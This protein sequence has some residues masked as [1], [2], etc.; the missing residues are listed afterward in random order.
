MRKVH[1]F[2]S[3][4]SLSACLMATPALA[5]PDGYYNTIFGVCLPNG[6]TVVEGAARPLTEAGAV[7]A[8]IVLEQWIVNSRNS[9][10]GSSS[11]IPPHIRYQ[12][13]P[14]FDPGVLSIARYKTGDSGFF[15]AGRNILFNGS[16][17]AVTLKDL[18]V[19][20]NF[21][22]SQSNV[23]LWAHELVHV[24]QYRDWGTR[25]FAIRYARD[26]NAVENEA[27]DME[28]RV[29]ATPPRV[30]PYQTYPNPTFP[31]PAPL[32]PPPMIPVRFCQTPVAT[33]PMQPTMIPMG[34]PCQCT[35]P[36]G[37]SIAGRA[38]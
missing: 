30:A 21:N 25:D 12:L 14:F 32:P 1:L 38:F 34:S 17:S 24:R 2:R 35:F 22:D 11:P 33:C 9:A 15:N 31:N 7:S 3:I 27:Y 18:I 6:D 23:A 29:A 20:R 19:F 4:L 37:Q 28:N 16:V 8:G 5:C 10:I 36:N 13:E 26:F